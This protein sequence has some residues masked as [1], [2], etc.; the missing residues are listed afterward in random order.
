MY[1]CLLQMLPLR[2]CSRLLNRRLK[3]KPDLARRSPATY[4]HTLIAVRRG[5]DNRPIVARCACLCPTGSGV[6]RDINV[7]SCCQQFGPI[8]GRAS[9]CQFVTGTLV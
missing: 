3:P 1:K 5:S 4:G 6:A 2:I 8:L 7:A 9:E